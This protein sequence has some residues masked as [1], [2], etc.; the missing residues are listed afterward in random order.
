M[1][2]D[3]K[4]VKEY[5]DFLKDSDY[6]SFTENHVDLKKSC[7]WLAARVENIPNVQ[8]LIE[9]EPDIAH[10]DISSITM[11][12]K[13]REYH[14][15][16]NFTNGYDR[17]NADSL[18]NIIDALGFEDASATVNNQPPGVMMGRHTDSLTC[19]LFDHL[20]DHENI[21]FDN[22][23]RQPANS[24]K[25]YRCFVAL[26]DWHPG[27]IVNFEPHFWTEWKK[28]D[29]VFFEWRHTPHGTANLGS[30]DRPFL[31]ITGSLSNDS[32]VYNAK[33][34]GTVRKI[35]L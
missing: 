11:L 20:E 9:S 6:M 23:L 34:Y 26:D 5:L 33:N 24:K 8:E 22:E 19:Y 4:N 1:K 27:Q 12:P 16:N 7:F 25:I 13:E 18:Q 35:T 2:T 30:H 21:P 10:S 15:K 3:F 17:H 14:E 28:G 32:W 29:V 31:K